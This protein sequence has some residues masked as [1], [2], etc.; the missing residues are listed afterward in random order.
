MGVSPGSPGATGLTINSPSADKLRK[1]HVGGL[2]DTHAADSSKSLGSSK[3]Y[4]DDDIE[5]IIQQ[6]PDW[7]SQLSLRGYIIGG[8]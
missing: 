6:L 1:R 7:K 4:S 8:C 2:A 5:E 3:P